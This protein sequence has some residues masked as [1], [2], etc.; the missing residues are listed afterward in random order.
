MFAMRRPM[1][2]AALVIFPW[3]VGIG[4]PAM[5]YP[6]PHHTGPYP[7]WIV[8]Q[9]QAWVAAQQRAIQQQEWAVARQQAWVAELNLQEH[10]AVDGLSAAFH[11][12]VEKINP[13]Q[14]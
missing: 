4:T 10:S 8:A 6:P 7:P 12:P 14:N 5:A 1:K 13:D 3:L 9:H 11:S 2:C